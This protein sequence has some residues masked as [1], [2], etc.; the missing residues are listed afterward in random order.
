MHL[1]LDITW[2]IRDLFIVFAN[3]GVYDSSFCFVLFCFCFFLFF[4]FW[5]YKTFSNSLFQKFGWLTLPLSSIFFNFF[6]SFIVHQRMLQIVVASLLRPFLSFFLKYE[7]YFI[8][9]DLP[10]NL[11]SLCKSYN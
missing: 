1:E 7:L 2:V 3:W 6:Y 11:S 4:F 5:L 8:F 10:F 9:V